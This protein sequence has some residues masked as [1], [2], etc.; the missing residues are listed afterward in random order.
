M[1]KGVRE[2]GGC[3]GVRKGGGGEGE[4]VHRGRVAWGRREVKV[5]RIEWGQSQKG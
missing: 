4:E 1:Y 2:G 5:E 3:E